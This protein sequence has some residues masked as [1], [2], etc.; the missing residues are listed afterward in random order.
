MSLIA[1]AFIISD[2]N[3]SYRKAAR[4]FLGAFKGGP[5]LVVCPANALLGVVEGYDELLVTLTMAG[6]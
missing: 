1:S 4:L 2:K 6:H 5:H 3:C